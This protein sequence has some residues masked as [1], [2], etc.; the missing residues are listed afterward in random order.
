MNL[1]NLTV[2]SLF[3]LL[4]AALLDCT[5]DTAEEDVDKCHALPAAEAAGW[6]EGPAI[7]PEGTSTAERISDA[8]AATWALSLDLLRGTPA[9]EHP[10]VAA[11][12]AGMSIALGMTALRHEGSL[13]EAEI[14][15]AMHAP[16]GGEALHNTLGAALKELESRSMPAGESGEAAVTLSMTPSLWDFRAGEAAGDLAGEPLYGAVRHSVDPGEKDENTAAIREVMNCVIESQSQGLLPGFLP[17]DHPKADTSAYDLNIA[18][19]QAPWANTLE[20]RGSEPFTLESGAVVETKMIG[21]SEQRLRYYESPD[22]AAVSVPLR[23]E[24]SMLL[25]LPAEGEFASLSEFT[26]HLT[27]ELLWAARDE[28]QRMA[29]D[30]TLPRF[31]ID[32]ATID[33]YDSLGLE[34]DPFTLRA[35]LHGAAIEVD[36]KGLKAAAAAANESWDTDGGGWPEVELRMDRPFLF[37]VYD[38]ATHFVLFSGRYAGV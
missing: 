10:S 14:R 35:V 19:L 15:E 22:L 33:Y 20:S 29:I 25:V 3:S 30:L 1:K 28:G 18:V 36:E 34:C 4:S 31:E 32:G 8:G 38:D 37:F 12:P 27:P 9:G 26:D 5:P 17:E 7:S 2:L 11:S 23:G 21:T 13:C 6:V 24:M 16:E